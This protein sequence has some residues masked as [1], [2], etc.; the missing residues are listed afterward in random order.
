M[1]NRPKYAKHTKLTTNEIKYGWNNGKEV[2][3]ESLNY[4]NYRD[5]NYIFS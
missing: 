1:Q 5:I 3:N 2:K 4:A